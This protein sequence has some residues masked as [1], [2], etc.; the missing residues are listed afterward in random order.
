MAA[1]DKPTIADILS[2][3]KGATKTVRVLLDAEIANQIEQLREQIKEASRSS[4]R[5]D[6]GMENPVPG[7]QKKIDKLIAAAEKNGMFAEFTFKSVGRKRFD[8]LVREHEPDEETRKLGGQWNPETFAPALLSEA[9]V[10]PAMTLEEAKQLWDSDEWN[11]AELLELFQAA[12][13]VNIE[14]PNVPLFRKG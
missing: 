8:D 1:A 10:E 12:I 6:M 4:S 5:A 9:C 7:L 3:K 14:R 2:K 13:E 11:Q